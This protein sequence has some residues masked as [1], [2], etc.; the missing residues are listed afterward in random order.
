M[1]QSLQND[2][3]LDLGGLT[4]EQIAAM[5]PDQVE[6]YLSAALKDEDQAGDGKP[7]NDASEP[8]TDQDDAKSATADDEGDTGSD[9]TGGADSDFQ[10]LDPYAGMADSTSARQS[11]DTGAGEARDEATAQSGAA[12][13]AAQADG[14]AKSE[15]DSSGDVDWKAKY[16]ALKVTHDML[17][18]SFKASGRTVKV[19]SPDDARRLMQMGYDYTNKMRDMKPH[20]KILKTLEHNDLLDAEKINFAIDLMK[21]NPEAVKKF[22]KD[23]KIDP[24][25]LDLESGTGYKPTDHRPS[26]EQLALDEVLDSIRGSEAF[27]RT[28]K[29]ITKEWDKVSQQVL[30]GNPRIIAIL[31]DHM[32]KGYYDQIATKVQYERSLGRLAGLSDLDAYKAVGDAMQAQGAFAPAGRSTT[33]AAETGQGPSQDSKG[34]ADVKDRKRAASPT[35][36]GAGAGK[37][38]PK[39][40]L[41]DFT[42]EEIEKMGNRAL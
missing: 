34:S 33:P 23:N 35:K 22:L 17:M 12:D 16:E 41:G 40:F 19:E 27:P 24:I 1:T 26:D 20:L 39:N 2:E 32:E 10:S 25:E 8:D 14:A 29:V 37:P 3:A 13:Q 31:N 6:K 15:A 30:M 21:G 9:D 36:G 38:A 7:A 11:S 28:A 42:D 4:D 18:G 5:S